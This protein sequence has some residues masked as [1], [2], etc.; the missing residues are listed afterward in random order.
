MK[1][2][3]KTLTKTIFAALAV[4]ILLSLFTLQVGAE[5]GTSLQPMVTETGKINISVD[6]LGTS[7]SG[8]IQ[9]E[10]PEGATVRGAYLIAT[11]LEVIRS[12]M[13]AF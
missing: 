5:D 10:K 11:G 13:E 6:G 3:S 8:I 7:G 12:L 4:F 2:K 9:V 1:Y